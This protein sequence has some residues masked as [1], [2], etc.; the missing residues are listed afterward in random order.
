MRRFLTAALVICA[1]AA[2]FIDAQ[3]AEESAA[4]VK[5]IRVRIS[6]NGDAL[7]DFSINDKS[8]ADSRAHSTELSK[9][10]GD[11]AMFILI[12]NT[13]VDLVEVEPKEG[14]AWPFVGAGLTF[15][16]GN[17]NRRG[18]GAIAPNIE[19]GIYAYDMFVTCEGRRIGV[20]P[21]MDIV[22]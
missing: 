10:G 2:L 8:A 20:D 11:T 21:K 5:Q 22:P 17:R 1:A 16:S 18:T 6:C 13:N 14:F 7:G 4:A 9:S 19:L 15:G 3:A 12:G